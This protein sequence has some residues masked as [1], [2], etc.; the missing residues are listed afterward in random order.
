MGLGFGHEG[1]AP[2]FGSEASAKIGTLGSAFS[3]DE[4]T[5]AR[6]RELGLGGFRFS[7]LGLA[8]LA[9]GEPVTCSI[10]RPDGSSVPFLCRHSFSRPQLA[11]F[12]AGSALNAL[13]RT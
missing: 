2:P 1:R 9:P 12:R 5:L 6:G 8:A 10:V 4:L 7:V 13:G 11:W 3:F